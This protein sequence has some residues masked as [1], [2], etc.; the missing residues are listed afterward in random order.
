MVIP[1]TRP[2]N[3]RD[4]RRPREK[5]VDVALAVDFVMGLQR[6]DF[7]IGVIFSDDTD[8]Y[9]ALEAAGEIAGGPG[10][11]ELV[12]WYDAE[13]GPRHPL[14]GGQP[15][16]TRILREREFRFLADHTDYTVKTPRKPR[17]PKRDGS[18]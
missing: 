4:S 12:T 5:G 18:E 10:H 3:Y 8:L 17:P 2:L 14:S 1:H 9:P 6:R 13:H 11:A 7:D 16:V 15:V